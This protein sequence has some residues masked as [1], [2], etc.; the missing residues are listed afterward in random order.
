MYCEGVANGRVQAML[1]NQGG[2]CLGQRVLNDS[3]STDSKLA[4]SMSGRP[5]GSYLVV[6]KTANGQQ[7]YKF[8]K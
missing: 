3:T 8:M 2:V 7:V 4:F 5:N 6:L 1:V